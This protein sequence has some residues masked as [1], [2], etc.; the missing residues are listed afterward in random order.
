M[1]SSKPKKIVNVDRIDNKIVVSYSDESTAIFS[2]AQ[3][4]Q[5]TPERVIKREQS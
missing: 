4:E 1:S 2:A 5:I 3:L